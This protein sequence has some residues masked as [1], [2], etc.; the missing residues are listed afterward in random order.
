MASTNYQVPFKDFPLMMNGRYI[1]V[2][3]VQVGSACLIN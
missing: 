1:Q 3:M 2:I